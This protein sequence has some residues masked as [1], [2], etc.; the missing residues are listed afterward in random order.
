MTRL[1]DLREACG[2]PARATLRETT[3]G[4]LG[5]DR[6]ARERGVETDRERHCTVLSSV[7][8]APRLSASG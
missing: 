3:D 6:Q 5:R 1:A 8:R 7:P 4:L 2:S